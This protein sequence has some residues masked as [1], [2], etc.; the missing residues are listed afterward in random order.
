MSATDP[1]TRKEGAWQAVRVL[2]DHEG[3]VLGEAV[4]EC[5]KL[6]LGC[7]LL[8]AEV[9]PAL[10]NRVGE[11]EDALRGGAGGAVPLGV[12]GS[13]LDLL[14]HVPAAVDG[15][16]LGLAVGALRLVVVLDLAVLQ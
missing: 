1:A 13:G 5:P 9:L 12:A 4:Q 11:F 10:R 16:A 15:A 8:K 2:A 6:A 3:P 7:E 14:G